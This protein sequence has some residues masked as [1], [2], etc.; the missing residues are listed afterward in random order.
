[1]T[2]ASILVSLDLSAAAAAR[3]RL[4]TR[5]A[6]HFNAM[7]TGVA[8]RKIPNPGP[9]HDLAEIQTTYN[10]EQAKLARDLERCRDLFEQNADADVLTSWLQ[11]EAN[12]ADFLVRQALA[13][14]VVVVGRESEEGIG[15]MSALPGAVLMEVG[16][17]VLMTP[18][19]SDDLRAERIVVAWKD[20]PEARRAVSAALPFLRRAKHVSVV[21]AGEEARSDGADR[22][23]E[24]LARHGAQVSQ[25]LL[26]ANARN[27]ADEILRFV[28]QADA[29]L[30]VMGGYGRSRLREWLFGG[31]TRDF[32]KRSPVCCLMSH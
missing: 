22:V 3:V 6:K 18:P 2:I 17:P 30:V 26:G 7:L 10:E 5:L 1:M 23:A 4:S 29:D 19:G 14:D 15:E 16:R 20:A 27:V 13:A 31:V 25:H 28:D 9:G 11:A 21:S 12:A 32:L 24:F 8:A